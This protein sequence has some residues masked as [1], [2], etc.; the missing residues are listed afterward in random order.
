MNSYGKG[1]SKLPVLPAAGMT[2]GGHTEP[3]SYDPEYLPGHPANASAALGF[4]LE[5]ADADKLFTGGHEGSFVR[6][7]GGIGL[8]DPRTEQESDRLIA[9]LN[10]ADVI[11]GHNILGFDLLALAHHHGADYDALAAKSVDTMV[12]ARLLDP[13]GAKGALPWGAR[14]YYGLDQVAQRLGHEGKTD[15]LKTLAKRHGGYDR[16]PVDD[17]EYNAYLRGDLEATKAVYQA[18][19][20]KGLSAYAEREMKIV[21]L[22]NRMS[23]NGW[24]VDEEELAARV[25]REDAQRAGAI[26]TL[27]EFGVP[28]KA[29]DRVKFKPKK[30]W[31]AD[32]QH[33]KLT[34]VRTWSQGDVVGLGLADLIPGEPHKSPWSTK[35]GRPAIEAAFKAAGAPY[36]PRTK[37]GHVALSKMAL[38]EEPWYDKNQGKSVP[39]LLQIYSDKLEVRRLAETLLL[40]TGARVKYAEIAKFVTG[41]RVHAE[42]SGSRPDEADGSDQASGRWAMRHPSIT[43]MGKRGAAKE[44]RGVL[45]ADPGHVLIT[46]DHSQLDVRTVAALSQ[47]PVLMEMLA[48]GA[49]DYHTTMAEI[50]F[51]DPGRRDD[52]KPISHG[53]NYGQGWKAIAE[54]N[55]LDHALVQAAVAARGDKFHVL[56]EWTD[57]VRD[58]A[59]RGLLLDNGFGRLMRCDPERAYT[60]APALM[61]Q[62]AARDVMCESLLRLAQARPDVRPYLRAVVHDEIVLSVPENEV[63]EW[64]EELRRAMT[65]E[66]RGVPILCDVSKP[67]FR[68]SDCK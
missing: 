30:D 49:A 4:D 33:L 29:P 20:E 68:W 24:A 9:R 47:D 62:G 10:D 41:G 32:C 7:V 23:L 14:G 46:C 6:L 27:A 63:E 55:R 40:A 8:D 48:V 60:Q 1:A 58:Q 22:Q 53:L 37:D 31:P 57:A 43:N 19:T 11:Y 2:Y 18:L 54:R 3:G 28:L 5:T 21:A 42:I 25:V 65:W 50:Y 16:I 66:W 38:G 67:A 34:E 56:M 59:E 51:G 36:L 26:E 52:G 64:Q 13:P 17:A 44:E 12:L 61:G 35:E 39:G 15:D 45:V